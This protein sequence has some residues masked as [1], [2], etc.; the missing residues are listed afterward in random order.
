MLISD[1]DIVACFLPKLSQLAWLQLTWA[2]IDELIKYVTPEQ[3][4]SL[5]ITRFGGVF[6]PAMSQYVIGS[7]ISWERDFR[8]M[9]KDQVNHEW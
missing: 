3:R 2:G 8:K 1:P 6:G 9:W 7:I 4:S 5:T